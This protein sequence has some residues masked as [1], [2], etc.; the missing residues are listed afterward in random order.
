[1]PNQTVSRPVQGDSV[2]ELA[3]ADGLHQ[4]GGNDDDQAPKVS[5]PMPTAV[6]PGF[7]DQA[8]TVMPPRRP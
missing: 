5:P 3:S 1:M 7:A 6:V 4:F 8:G 2:Y